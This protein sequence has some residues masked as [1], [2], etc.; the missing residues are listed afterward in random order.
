MKKKHLLGLLLMAMAIGVGFTS[1]EKDD[2][3]EGIEF[4]MRNS[5]NGG[6]R[7]SILWMDSAYR[8]GTYYYASDVDLGISVSNNFYVYSW[9]TNCSITCVGSVSNIR[10]INR[11]PEFGWAGEVSVKPGNGYIIRHENCNGNCRYARVYV[12]DWIEST[13]GGIIGAVIRYQ[14]NWKIEE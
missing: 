12:E 6:D 2:G 11:I 7:I 4:R 1:C 3:S 8:D 13:D 14:D 5:D 9:Y 10:R